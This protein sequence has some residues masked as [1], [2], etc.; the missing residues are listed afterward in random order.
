MHGEIWWP[1]PDIHVTADIIVIH[2]AWHKKV[3]SVYLLFTK[4]KAKRG[5]LFISDMVWETDPNI[6]KIQ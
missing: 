6:A 1:L 5:H 2:F 3:L 4:R